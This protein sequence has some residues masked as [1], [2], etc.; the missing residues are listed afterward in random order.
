MRIFHFLSCFYY[1]NC[2]QG[3][4]MNDWNTPSSY[5]ENVHPHQLKYEVP[6]MHQ[7]LGKLYVIFV[8]GSLIGNGVVI[9]IFSTY[10]VYWQ[11][12]ELK[13]QRPAIN[14]KHFSLLID[15][16]HEILR[17]YPLTFFLP[18]SLFKHT[19]NERYL[20]LVIYSTVVH[21]SQLIA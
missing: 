19:N 1:F 10:Y 8:Q 11:L 18:N 12:G 9:Y 4:C 14:H 17:V 5:L 15:Y 7:I 16:Q 21:L 2:R 20:F 6:F 13:E 3:F